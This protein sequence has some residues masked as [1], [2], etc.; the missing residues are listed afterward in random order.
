MENIFTY[1]RHTLTFND[2]G[3]FMLISS[4]NADVFAA[5]ELLVSPSNKRIPWESVGFLDTRAYRPSG[6]VKRL[7]KYNIRMTL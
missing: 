2:Y 7:S 5:W 6:G 4:S 1:H 3:T